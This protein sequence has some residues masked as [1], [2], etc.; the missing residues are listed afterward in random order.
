MIF[1]IV[2]SETRAPYLETSIKSLG[3]RV[4]QWEVKGC[5]GTKHEGVL[6]PNYQYIIHLDSQDSLFWFGYE[7]GI[8]KMYSKTMKGIPKEDESKEQ[9]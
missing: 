5:K 4:T 6:E 1:E 8:N 7:I 3:K 9:E 2:V